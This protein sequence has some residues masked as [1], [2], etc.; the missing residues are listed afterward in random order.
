MSNIFYLRYG[1]DGNEQSRLPTD[2]KHDNVSAW[3]FC[4][5]SVYNIIHV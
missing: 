2:C 4:E 3:N 1:N 5:M